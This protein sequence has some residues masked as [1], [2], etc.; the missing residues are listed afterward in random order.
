M[1]VVFVNAL[2]VGAVAEPKSALFCS[3][4]LTGATCKLG[5]E[6]VQRDL[7][8]PVRPRSTCKLTR[9]LWRGAVFETVQPSH[10]LFLASCG[11]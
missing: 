6:F 9:Y 4:P 1:H 2:V 11:M 3:R 8:Q 10:D 5:R 7:V